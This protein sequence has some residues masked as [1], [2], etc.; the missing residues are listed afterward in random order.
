MH[1]GDRRGRRIVLGWFVVLSPGCQ[2]GM[3]GKTNLC[4]RAYNFVG[5]YVL[6]AHVNKNARKRSDENLGRVDILAITICAVL[7]T[8]A[9]ID[10]LKTNLG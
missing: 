3:V 6:N 9:K 5:R 8:N 2:I 4:Y 1:K 10:V 7:Y